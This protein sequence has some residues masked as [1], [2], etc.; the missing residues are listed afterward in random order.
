MGEESDE[1][2]YSALTLSNRSKTVSPRALAITSQ[3][4]IVGFA[5]P[6]STRLKYV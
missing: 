5:L 3:A 1:L 2:P 6:L 4:L